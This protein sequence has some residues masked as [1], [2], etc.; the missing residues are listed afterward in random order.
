MI[1]LEQQAACLPSAQK[2]SADLHASLNS[3]TRAPLSYTSP[4]TYNNNEIG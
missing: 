1:D 3:V 4:E 2:A